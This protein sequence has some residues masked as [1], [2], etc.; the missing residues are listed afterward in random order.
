M[1]VTKG[2]KTSNAYGKFLSVEL[3]Q[4]R[5]TILRALFVIALIASWILL[6]INII[7]LLGEALLPSLLGSETTFVIVEAV[8]FEAVIWMIVVVVIMTAL[9]LM[10]RRPK[11]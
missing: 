10:L 5:F 9:N 3:D 11:K 1:S 2:A 4:K 6:V 8:H 7:D